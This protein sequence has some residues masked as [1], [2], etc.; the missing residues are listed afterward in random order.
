MTKRL[1][2]ACLMAVLLFADPIWAQVPTQAMQI[3]DVRYQSGKITLAALLMVPRSERPLPAAV[4]IQGSGSSDR[5]NQWAREIAEQLI[6]N[7]V[8][9]LL[10]DKRGSG[11]SCGDWRVAG[12]SDLAADALAGV[13]FLRTRSEIDRQ[14]VGLV[15]LSQGG[16]VAPL[17]A[18]RSD[19]VAFVI[20][21]SGA[22]VGFAEQTFVEMANTARQA[23]LSEPLV[24]EVIRL[25]AAAA[26][27]VTTGDWQQ[28]ERAR[29]RALQT[30]ARAI[31]AGFPATA[32]EPIWTF[33]RSVATYDP[34][35]YWVHVAQ[36][37]FVVYGEE[38][39]RDNVPVAESVRRL[40]H[41]FRSVNKANQRVLVVAGAG[42]AI[43][44]PQTHRLA[45]R[46]V[47]ALA[48][49]LQEH[50]SR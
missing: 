38:D 40:E 4:I 11:A 32:D 15:G 50:V 13:A 37:V 6:R 7:G 30:G 49:W 26:K 44:D 41:V 5:T 23:G 34:L 47:D 18:A 29:T 1:T 9:V 14:R 42:H 46:F 19:D 3:V 10:T 25:N 22:T 16:S 33:L 45:A 48:A 24:E 28:Y 21:I 27:Y 35:P 20:N 31:A 43:R 17:A 8:A 36:P 2:N 39:E 12:F